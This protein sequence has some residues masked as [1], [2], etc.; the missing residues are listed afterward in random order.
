MRSGRARFARALGGLTVVN[1]FVTLLGFVSGP[2]QAREL[3]PAGRGELAAAVVVVT[4][5]PWFLNLGLPAFVAREVATEETDQGTLFGTVIVLGLIS[6]LVGW[7]WALPVARLVAHG[8][9]PVELLI[10]LGFAFLPIALVGNV[11]SGAFWGGQDWRGLSTL[12]LLAPGLVVIGFLGLAATHHFTVATAAG[13]TFA[14]G[15]G[16]LAPLVPLVWHTRGWRFDSILASRALRWGTRMWLGTLANL[17]NLRLDQLLM[18]GLV[19]AR[20]LGLYTVA[21]TTSGFTAVLT[22]SLNFLVLPLVARGDRASVRRI[23]RITLVGT[24]AGCAVLA[25]VAPWIV[26]VLFGQAFTGSVT[27]LQVLVVGSVLLAGNGV[28]N[29]ALGGDGHP[30]D[31]A[32]AE[33][34]GL[35]LTIPVLVLVLPTFGAMG[36]AVVSDLSYAVVFAVLLLRA[37]IR[38]GGHL[39]EYLLPTPTDLAEL[40]AHA[41]SRGAAMRRRH[42][43]G[44]S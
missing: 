38:L 2:L 22:Q 40:L 24:A 19:P 39:H 3:G 14:A 1:V 27:L 10:M 41:R 21:V 26:P 33:G 16:S 11:L 43:G 28:L 34:I 18:A 12:R 25:L 6:S 29:A 15:L 42:A 17:G 20:E 23:L 7:A 13:V 36:A 44:A 9:R 4:L 37:R 30:G 5:V 8:R 31:T 35:G 32:L